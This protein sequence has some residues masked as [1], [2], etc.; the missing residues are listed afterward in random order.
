MPV[1]RFPG[2]RVGAVY[3]LVPELDEWLRSPL[4]ADRDTDE[5][6][7][8]GPAD[9]GSAAD[10]LAARGGFATT[11]SW[12]VVAAAF[13]LGALLAGGALWRWSGTAGGPAC[14]V[15][16]EPASIEIPGSGGQQ[17][18]AV[19]GDAA[20]AWRSFVPVPWMR[21]DPETGTAPATVR[22]AL[23]A[24]HTTS[25]RIA[26]LQI[27]GGAVRVVQ[28]ANPTG[29]T[30]EPGPGYVKDGYRY[31][32]TRAAVWATGDLLGVAR[33]EGGPT[34]VGFGWDDLVLL[35]ETRPEEGDR[36]AREV[37]LYQ[38]SWESTQ[39]TGACFIY[40]LIEN[41]G[42][43]E[44]VTYHNHM[45]GEDYKSYKSINGNQFDL[46]RWNQQNQVLYRVPE[47]GS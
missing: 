22:L 43:P 37:G 1:H 26:T 23:P 16:V 7:G 6:L 10:P 33:S 38:H 39:F 11:T 20:C 29:C 13:A 46:G 21:L 12:P 41:A 18:I 4:S 45:K 8:E 44:F 32:I 31:R 30:S 25:E 24:N 5:E 40:W 9:P 19:G 3:A 47:P 2:G 34:A 14:T 17:A 28:A 27:G 35:L 42:E 15:A 36:F